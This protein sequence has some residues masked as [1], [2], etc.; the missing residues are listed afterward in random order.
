MVDLL[1]VGVPSL[2]FTV[3]VSRACHFQF[4]GSSYCSYWQLYFR[5]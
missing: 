3:T 1:D 4:A 5:R 2:W